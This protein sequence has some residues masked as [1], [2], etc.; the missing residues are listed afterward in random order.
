VLRTVGL[1]IE[2]VGV[3]CVYQTSINNAQQHASSASIPVILSWIA[4][5]AGFLLWL[6]GRVLMFSVQRSKSKAIWQDQ[7]ELS[8]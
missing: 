3:G 1:V 6:T 4:V 5:G 7:R 2:M 8:P